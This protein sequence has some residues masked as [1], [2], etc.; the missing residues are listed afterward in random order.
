M[1]TMRSSDLNV[2]TNYGESD[3]PPL[4][5]ELP[6]GPVVHQYREEVPAQYV[7]TKT[8][9]AGYCNYCGPNGSSYLISSE[10]FETRCA[11]SRRINTTTREEEML[12]PYPVEVV[13][14]AIHLVRDPFDNAVARS[15]SSAVNFP[16]KFA[17][18]SGR[19]AYL[20]YCQM[21]DA[22]SVLPPHVTPSVL[23]CA[24]EFYKYVQWHNNVYEMIERHPEWPIL[25]L[26]YESYSIDS[27][28]TLEEVMEFL[29][30]PTVASPE[31]FIA[32]KTYDDHFTIEEARAALSLVKEVASVQTWTLVR[33][34]FAKWFSES[35]LMSSPV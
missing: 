15:H 6:N 27:N 34:Y 19:G 7:L 16:M 2:A 14:K 10:K 25:T 31:P 13:K 3:Q 23:P 8:H 21:R 1:N 35:E 20:A 22:H 12:P 18:L 4:Y 17:S 33:P 9:C 5:S 11:T 24:S 30:L 29:E 26:R 32:N 28:R